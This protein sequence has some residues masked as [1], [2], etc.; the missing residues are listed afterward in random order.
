MVL[1]PYEK[2]TQIS[3]IVFYALLWKRVDFTH[4]EIQNSRLETRE[5]QM[6]AR[7]SLN[8]KNYN[9]NKNKGIFGLYKQ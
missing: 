4:V 1:D 5:T 9:F 2:Y 8:S 3:L 7:N 6:K